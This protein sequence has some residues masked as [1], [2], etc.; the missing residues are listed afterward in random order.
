MRQ[1]HCSYHAP[2]LSS[3]LALHFSNMRNFVN[4]FS[5]YVTVNLV[6]VPKFWYLVFWVLELNFHAWWLANS[7]K[8]LFQHGY[9][10]WLALHYQ[11]LI[12]AINFAL[13]GVVM[14]VVVVIFIAAYST[15]MSPNFYSEDFPPNV[16]SKFDGLGDWYLLDLDIFF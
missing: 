3:E 6:P 13:L 9:R 11:S 15:K 14:A 1:S 5:Q 4:Y 16:D 12:S 8:R 2:R 10:W 7:A